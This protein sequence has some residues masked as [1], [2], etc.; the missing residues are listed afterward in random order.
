MSIQ[1]DTT[2]EFENTVGFYENGQKINIIEFEDQYKIAGS[3][4]Q[5]GWVISIKNKKYVVQSKY[6]DTD[7]TPQYKLNLINI[8]NKNTEYEHQLKK[9]RDLV[10]PKTKKILPPPSIHPEKHEENTSSTDFLVDAAGFGFSYSSSTIP[11]YL[12]VGDTGIFYQLFQP[13]TTYKIILI[14][15]YEFSATSFKIMYYVEK[16]AT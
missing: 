9:A 12:N 11:K 8:N 5:R 6:F 14:E 10:N 15:Y 1:S 13:P 3:I 4:A 16:L 2:A 7:A